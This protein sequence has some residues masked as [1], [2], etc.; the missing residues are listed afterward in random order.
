MASE[1]HWRAREGECVQL[2]AADVGGGATYHLR[3]PKDRRIRV[4]GRRIE[5]RQPN[6]FS[7]G[8]TLDGE[9]FDDVVLV[10]FNSDWSVQYAY[11]LPLEAARRHHKQP[12]RQG[13]RLMIRGDDRWRDDPDVERLA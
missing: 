7:L 8:E 9:P 4:A 12:G 2:S 5:G 10:L 1:T 6:F 13:C 3:D 11:R